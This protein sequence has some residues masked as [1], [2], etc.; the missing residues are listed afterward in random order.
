MSTIN[1][2]LVGFLYSGAA[3]ALAT[4]SWKANAN[5]V[6]G[7]NKEG[8]GYQVFKPGNTFNSLT[9]LVPDGV[10]ILDAA[11]LGFE[12]PGATLA[13]GAAASPLALLDFTATGQTLANNQQFINVDFT[14]SSTD[15]GDS[16]LAM[17]VWNQTTGFLQGTFDMG[18]V[19][20]A[21]TGAFDA[22]SMGATLTD[23]YR[24]DFITNQGHTITKIFVAT[25]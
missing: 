11:K 21:A 14:V 12:L 4:A 6:Y 22:H 1:K 19:N 15:L 2:K 10:Y 25:A 7:L 5:T 20:A 17:V 16:G 13:A 23:T 24:I 9:Q 3:Q 18:S 8:T